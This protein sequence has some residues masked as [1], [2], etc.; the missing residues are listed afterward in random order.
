MSATIRSSVDI[1]ATDS[2]EQVNKLISCPTHQETFNRFLK[3]LKQNLKPDITEDEVIKTL[4]LN[5]DQLGK[6]HRPPN[7]GVAF[8]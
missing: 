7:G 8:F 3:E 2:I 6:Y 5:L 1:I 4:S